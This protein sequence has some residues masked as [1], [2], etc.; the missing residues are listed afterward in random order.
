MSE[1]I[2]STSPATGHDDLAPRAAE[3]RVD[4]PPRRG[5][6]AWLFALAALAIA[7]IA[8][9]RVHALEHGQA[10][11]AAALRGELA[12]RVA[13]LARAGDQHKRDLDSMRARL[14]D[15]D[16]INKS[17]RE[18]L[19][20]LGERS[21][22]V[23][24]AVANLAEQRLSGRD[25]LAMNEAEFLLQQ[26][27]ERLILFRDAQAAIAAY[28]LAD[29]ALA[30]AEDPMF[31]SVRQTIDAELRALE[32]SK[33]VNTERAFAAL[34]RVRESLA[35]LSLPPAAGQESAATSRWGRFLAQF[36]RVS[37]SADTGAVAERD[38]DLTRRLAALDL[39]AAEAALLARDAEAYAAAVKRARAGIAV[40][41][42]TQATS[43]RSAL[44]ELDR[45]AT[46]PFAPALPELGSALRELR[47]LRATRALAQPPA[48]KPAGTPASQSG[49]GA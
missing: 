46:A 38:I 31:A 18:E 11:A 35:T 19:L 29:S 42:D 33:P 16:G 6:A 30:A 14:A 23:E 39:R 45:L 49:A 20:S 48:P 4:S 36:V 7:G 44:A 43:T 25:A 32:A 2:G 3:D 5:S 9:W 34:E 10:D 28:R 15:A 1:D 13:E 37:H 8:L 40:A 12:A 22:H 17:M 26:A 47:N 41:F 27:Q 21:R 24:D